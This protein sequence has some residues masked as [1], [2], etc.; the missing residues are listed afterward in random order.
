MDKEQ[1][2]F[3][4]RCTNPAFALGFLAFLLRK[5]ITKLK[6]R[7]GSHT[8]HYPLKVRHAFERKRERPVSDKAN[9]ARLNLSGSY[10]PPADNGLKL[11]TGY[12]SACE[13]K[14]WA[15]SFDDPEQTE[16]LHRWGWLLVRL[17]DG[18]QVGARDWGL[19]QMRGWLRE[20]GDNIAGPAWESYTIGE[21][22]CNAILFFFNS[23]EPEDSAVELPEDVRDALAAMAHI[24]SERL[25]YKEPAWT[26]NHVINNARALYFAGRTLND[27]YLADLAVA[28][29]RNDLSR[30]IYR[31][32]F[33]REGSS[34]YH[35]LV[36]RWLLEI[37]WLARRTEDREVCGFV[38]PIA[39][40]M[41]QRCWF[42]L[43]DKKDA[44]DWSIPLIGDVSPDFTWEWLIS[45]PWSAIAKSLYTPQPMPPGPR[46][47]GWASLFGAASENAGATTAR[48]NRKPGYQQFPESGWYRLDQGPTTIFWH[49]EPAGSPPFA[50]HGHCD[51]GSF[52]LFW[53]GAE[54]ITDP[55]RINYIPGDTLGKYG[56]SARAHNSLLVDGFEPFVY[57]NRNRYP[58]R[59]VV[60]NVD[61]SCKD[62]HDGFEISLRH[63]GFSRLHNDPI[64]FIRVIR[65]TS[66]E[67]MIVDRLEGRLQ[68][69]IDTYFQWGPSVS[70]EPG[71]ELDAF[72]VTDKES[73]FRAV[74]SATSGSASDLNYSKPKLVRGVSV[75]NP[76]GWYFPGYGE[77]VEASTLVFNVQAALPY[78]HRYSLRLVN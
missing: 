42:F 69:K 74:F 41:V 61:V 59:Y 17:T 77:R 11:A 9:T 8:A 3:I 21:R 19:N 72:M 15:L 30:L 33:L 71:D 65:A 27:N 22:I 62:R 51:I 67:I 47:A 13:R 26:G 75:P 52:C 2:N 24:L 50:S 53:N 78:E 48:I 32:G 66:D 68:H 44:G 38:E 46:R 20:M 36:T 10:Y 55:G 34:H 73:S 64:E 63:S 76:S 14:S 4:K 49:A 28:V 6:T 56:S 29:L 45:L 7:L 12:L 58:L 1:A 35:F 23:A 57:D 16:S 31:D 43:I 5:T 37:V 70:I 18:K 60:G 40:L 25:E 39:K 54:I